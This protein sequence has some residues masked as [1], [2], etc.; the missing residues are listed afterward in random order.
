MS[1]PPL[2]DL[3][4]EVHLRVTVNLSTGAV[5]R[6]AVAGKPYDRSLPIGHLRA[7]TAQAASRSESQTARAIARSATWPAT[8]IDDEMGR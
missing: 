5:E 1:T 4:Y 6:V 8:V 3:E 2:V 7:G